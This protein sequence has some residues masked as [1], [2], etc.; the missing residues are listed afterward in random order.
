M[1]EIRSLFELT[2]KEL[3][4]KPA[5]RRFGPFKKVQVLTTGWFSHF[6][7]GQAED[8]NHTL[9]VGPF[10]TRGGARRA[11]DKV[12]QIVDIDTTKEQFTGGW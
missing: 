2:P 11:W 9:I 7:Y 5:L 12:P 10:R 8:S 3:V 6:W 1:A 4:K